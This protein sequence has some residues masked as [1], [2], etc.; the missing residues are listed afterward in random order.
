MRELTARRSRNGAIRP[1]G[2]GVSASNTLYGS[3]L[4]HLN[5]CFSAIEVEQR[6][7]VLERCYWPLLRLT[8]RLPKLTLAI[9]ISGYTLECVEA[10]DPSWVRQL[11]R[12]IEAGRVELVGSGD[13]QLIGPLVSREVN[14]WNQRLG[15]ETYMRL[16][17]IHPRVALVNEM[18]W[19]QGIIDAYLE[20]GYEALIMEWN[21]PRRVH[22]EWQEEWRFGSARSASPSGREVQVLWANAVA[23]QKFQRVIAGEMEIED[24]VDWVQGQRAPEHGPARHLFLYANDAEI[25]DFRPGRFRAEPAP[26]SGESEWERMA[27]VL[28]AL[29]Q[30]GVRF[31]APSEACRFPGAQDQGCLTLNAAADPVPVKKQPKYNVTR[32]GLTGRDDVG[33]NARCFGRSRALTSS[34]GTPEQWRELCR[35]WA[36]D[37]RTH[38]TPGRWSDYLEH[39]PRVDSVPSVED[40][41]GLT[42]AEVRQEGKRLYVRTDGVELCLLARRGLAFESLHFPGFS[43][44]PLCGT[45]PHGHF[46][47]IDWAAD[48]YSGHAVL[49]IP[50]HSRV[51]DLERSEPELEVGEDSVRISAELR[52]SL[53]T[54]K[55]TVEVFAQHVEIFFGFSEWGERI[56]CSLRAGFITLLADGFGGDLFVSCA[57]GG[58]VERFA[59]SG[60]V[61]HGATVSPLVSAQ[62]GFGA[63]EGRFC[64]HDAKVGLEVSWPNWDVAALPLL[65]HKMIGGQRFVRIAFSL[66]EIDETIRPGARLNDFRMAL[67][68]KRMAA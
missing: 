42:V 51:T 29:E 37:L 25:F 22:P 2:L 48:F 3:L 47:D 24:Y 14:H 31:S 7:E 19:S 1:K 38:I 43:A 62:A 68:P 28:E 5:L 40:S 60:D 41:R 55:K 17:G 56:P 59:L 27:Q 33:I 15:Q 16:L 52:T 4:F 54:L 58:E 13:S 12:L 44:K 49:D 45:L 35:A 18:A 57:N 6:P 10:L 65:T 64:V 21:N 46:E 9:E 30:A 67:G 11:K 32:W 20:A 36:S 63:T 23:F 39:L 50:A 66:S 53:G 8:E 61:D 34:G 26:P